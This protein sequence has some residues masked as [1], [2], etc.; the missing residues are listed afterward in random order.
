MHKNNYNPKVKIN[1]YNEEQWDEKM[2][3]K[4]AP[5]RLTSNTEE[6]WKSI[7][8]SE[9]SVR[10]SIGKKQDQ[11]KLERLNRNSIKAETITKLIE[12]SPVT[13]KSFPGHQPALD[14]YNQLIGEKESIGDYYY[15]T[16]NQQEYQN[17][18]Q[19]E[20]NYLEKHSISDEELKNYNKK[21]I[22]PRDRE[23]ET[24][25]QSMS[26]NVNNSK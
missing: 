22:F 23:M 25:Y 10:N 7:Y 13:T 11:E 4:Y 5:P 2:S 26:T 21:W 18:K 1:N 14:P 3:I 19:R 16:T 20:K 24:T 17:P 9:H 6:S 12:N 15:T 8:T